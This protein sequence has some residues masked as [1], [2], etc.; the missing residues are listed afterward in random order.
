MFSAYENIFTTKIKRITVIGGLAHHLNALYCMCCYV[1]VCLI[2]NTNYDVLEI[3]GGFPGCSPDLIVS[4]V[5]CV[6]SFVCCS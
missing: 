5:Y 1:C 4:V 2:I 6:C 3:V